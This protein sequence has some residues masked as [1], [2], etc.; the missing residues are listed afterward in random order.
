LHGQRHAH[1][2]MMQ[3]WSAAAEHKGTRRA[4]P[5]V[6]TVSP[7][8]RGTTGARPSLQVSPP[9]SHCARVHSIGMDHGRVRGRWNGRNNKIALQEGIGA[10][11]RRGDRSDGAPGGRSEGAG[12]DAIDG[13]AA[14]GAAQCG[15]TRGPAGPPLR[16]D[17][18]CAGRGGARVKCERF[19]C[20]ALRPSCRAR[21]RPRGLAAGASA[22]AAAPV[23]A[24]RA[25]ALT[26][27]LTRSCA[28]AAAAVACPCL[29][30]RAQ[31]PAPSPGP[32]C[33]VSSAR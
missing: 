2:R 12:N 30:C 13:V 6:R 15:R 7:G 33:S 1:T 20:A 22:A 10:E 17:R 16:S 11:A 8:G 5:L 21:R 23:P 25:A 27:L 4:L 3:A 9:P 18:P 32:S 26:R 28:R 31:R 19:A 14:A 29:P 24:L